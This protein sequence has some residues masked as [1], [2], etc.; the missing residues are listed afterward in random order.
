MDSVCTTALLVH[1][2]PKS[3]IKLCMTPVPNSLAASHLVY[4]TSMLVSPVQSLALVPAHRGA[5]H[6]QFLQ[7]ISIF[8]FPLA[9]QN[10]S[11]E[12]QEGQGKVL[13]WQFGKKNLGVV[14]AGVAIVD[15]ATVVPVQGRRPVAPSVPQDL[16]L[17]NNMTIWLQDFAGAAIH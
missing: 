16:A 11:P 2:R 14:S 13:A 3:S 5:D 17:R 7:G 8:R 6:A 15:P 9:Q 12:A 4:L 1:V 10:L